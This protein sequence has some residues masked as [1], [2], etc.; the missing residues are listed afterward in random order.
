MR[1]TGVI[2]PIHVAI[3]GYGLAGRVFHAPLIAATP[4]LKLTAIVSSRRD[5]ISA[6]YLDAKILPDAEAVFG[7][8]AIDLVVVATPNDSHFD[9]ASRA[10]AAGKHVVIDKPFATTAAEA[11]I[12]IEKARGRLLSVFHNRRW[13]GDFLTLKKLIHGGALG[14]VA[15]IESRFDLFRPEVRAR[16]REQAGPA[17]GIW[18]DLGSHLVDQAVQLWGWPEAVYADLGARRPGAQTTD[19][20]R[21]IL[22]YR[23][24][25][26]VLAGDCLAQPGS[27]FVVHGSRAS[28]VAGGLDPQQEALAAGIGPENPAYGRQTQPAALHFAGGGRRPVALERGDYCAFYRG[29]RDT[30]RGIAPLPVTAG[31]AHAV[32][33]LLE[34]AEESARSGREIALNRALPNTAAPA[35]ENSY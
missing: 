33:T 6:A 13:D 9:L 21:V 32:M 4:G 10:L 7:D 15:A 2:N 22:R 5:E 24:V 17:S 14:C 19:Y 35:P 27:R 1:N 25:R 34:A 18:Y 20:F 31:E 23:T 11:A 26:A 8:P 30:L 29:I 12:L 28:F 16:W 3:L